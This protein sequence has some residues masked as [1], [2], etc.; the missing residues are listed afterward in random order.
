MELEDGLYSGRNGVAALIPTGFP[1]EH[2]YG[3]VGYCGGHG[4]QSSQNMGH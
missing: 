3:V 1:R 2:V 4:T